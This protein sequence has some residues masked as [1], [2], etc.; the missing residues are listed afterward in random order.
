MERHLDRARRAQSALRASKGL[1]GRLAGAPGVFLG[2]LVLIW[3][4]LPLVP[5]ETGLRFGLGYLI[6]FTIMVLL[7]ALFF[8]FLGKEH[9]PQPKS[10]WTVFLSLAAVYIVSVSS[11][12][13]VGHIYP[14]FERPRP[15]GATLKEAVERGK[16]LFTRDNV[17]CYRCHAVSGVGGIRGPDLTRVASRAG[18]RVAGRPAD[19]YLRE[20]ISAGLTY[21]F[22]V[23]EYDPIMPPFRQALTRDQIEDLVAF[24]LS[25]K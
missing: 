15:P 7:G 13:A 10:P 22:R 2:L 20:K 21:S 1:V 18:S 5:E 11:L 3:V 24:L 23:P 19:Q 12:V 17:G 9:I 16:E 8:W 25:L 4:G 14:Q 6:F